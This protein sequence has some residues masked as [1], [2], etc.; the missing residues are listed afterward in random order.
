[1]IRLVPLLPFLCVFRAPVAGFA[2]VG[3]RSSQPTVDLPFMLILFIFSI[4]FLAL[5]N[6]KFFLFDIDLTALL[7]PLSP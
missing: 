4:G 5:M 6:R 7:L 2:A 1:V 3:F